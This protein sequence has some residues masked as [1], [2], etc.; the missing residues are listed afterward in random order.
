MIGIG[1]PISQAITPFMPRDS[2]CQDG[3][4]QNAGTAPGVPPALE[5]TTGCAGSFAPAV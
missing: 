3:F 5:R 2:F 1:M 4:P